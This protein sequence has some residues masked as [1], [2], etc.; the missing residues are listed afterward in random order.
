M[1]LIGLD[2]NATRA[3]AVSAATGTAPRPLLLDGTHAD[4]P[5]ALSLQG[6]HPEAGRAGIKLCRLTPHLA[7]VD[8]LPELGGEKRWVAGRHRLDAAK[9]LTLVFERLRQPFAGAEGMA[10]VV[11]AY[12][13]LAQI[14]QLGSLAEKTRLPAIF[15]S[16]TAPLAAGL[17]AFLGQPWSGLAVVVDAD[18]HTLS[19][20]AVSAGREQAQVVG[21]RSLPRLGLRAWKDRVLDAVADRCVRHSRRDPRDSAPSEQMLFEQLDGVLDACRKG[22]MAELGIEA[23][24]WYQN[25]IL[26]PE[27]VTGFCAA[28]ARQVAE[29]LRAVLATVAARE[30]VA[31]L[32]LTQAA[33]RLPGLAS[34]LQE[35]AGAQAQ[36]FVAAADGPARVAHELAARIS[37]GEISR[38]HLDAVIPLPGKDHQ[39]EYRTQGQK[40][41]PILYS[42]F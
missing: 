31:A 36:L 20:T 13:S 16:V 6:R 35:A 9:A 37:L 10:V 34:A 33:S 12:T 15:G 1:T 23:P 26:G 21:E 4:L 14:K 32:V 18:D 7:C 27:E 25:V 30:P 5:L 28:L 24:H 8:F 3:L 29:G 11:P 41:G 17:A 39:P 40:V 19:C 2:L 42:G 22:Q 38:G